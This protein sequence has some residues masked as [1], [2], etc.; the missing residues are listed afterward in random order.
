MAFIEV[1]NGNVSIGL[2]CWRYWSRRSL[3]AVFTVK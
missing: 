3:N 2:I 1:Q